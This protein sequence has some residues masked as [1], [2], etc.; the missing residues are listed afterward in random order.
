MVPAAQSGSL[1][2]VCLTG[3]GAGLS[4]HISWLT[5]EEMYLMEEALNLTPTVETLIHA[6]DP[7]ATD[8]TNA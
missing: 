8:S 3:A 1:V 7:V 4:A 6:V 5:V 2:S